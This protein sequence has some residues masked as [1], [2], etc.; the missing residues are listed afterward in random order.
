VP[1][2]SLAGQ[3]GNFFAGV[4]TASSP[5]QGDD[6]DSFILLITML[7]IKQTIIIIN[8]IVK[9]YVKTA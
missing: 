1:P 2:A 9:S 5:D 3:P 4:G 6:A 7:M 8:S